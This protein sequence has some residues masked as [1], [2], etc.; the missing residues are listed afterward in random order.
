MGSA[1]FVAI[2]IVVV[3]LTTQEDQN[4]QQGI[5]KCW[6]VKIKGKTVASFVGHVMC[7]N[8]QNND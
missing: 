5:N 6:T 2:A 8:E 7:L 1:S 3:V 4:L